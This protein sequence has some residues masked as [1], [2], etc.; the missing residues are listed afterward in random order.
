MQVSIFFPQFL[1][2][3]EVSRSIE[4]RIIKGKNTKQR[5]RGK[6][7]IYHSLWSWFS[8]MPIHLQT[9]EQSISNVWYSG[10]L[11]NIWESFH[12]PKGSVHPIKRTNCIKNW[13]ARSKQVPSILWHFWAPSGSFGVICPSIYT[14]DNSGSVFSLVLRHCGWIPSQPEATRLAADGTL[15]YQSRIGTRSAIF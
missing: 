15:N 10:N 14:L 6:I 3:G 5:N 13:P 8:N 9:L 12:I 2:V 1:S 4:Q 11:A 7:S